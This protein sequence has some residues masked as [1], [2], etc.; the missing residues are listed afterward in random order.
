MTESPSENAGA[1]N[2][3]FCGVNN[4]PKKEKRRREVTNLRQAVR[5]REWVSREGHSSL[6][7]ADAFCGGP[8]QASSTVKVVTYNV[9]GPLHGEIATQ[10]GF[11]IKD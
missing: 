8:G 4:G 1:V 2:P 6:A 9:L 5:E 11:L 3:M 10:P 7:D